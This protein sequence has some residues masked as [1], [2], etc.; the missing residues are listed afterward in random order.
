D[1]KE[2]RK[3]NSQNS[4]GPSPERLRMLRHHLHLRS[5]GWL[6]DRCGN[7][8]KD[9]NAEFDSDEDEPPPPP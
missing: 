8:V 4:E 7:W 6:Q 1:S 3:E 5:R 9:E 2:G